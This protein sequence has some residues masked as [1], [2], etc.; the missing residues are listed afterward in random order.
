MRFC[1]DFLSLKRLRSPSGVPGAPLTGRGSFGGPG[2]PNV[3]DYLRRKS[4]GFAFEGSGFL[5]SAMPA[6]YTLSEAVAWRVWI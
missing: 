4:Q 3:T 2:T 1:D 6:V 5:P